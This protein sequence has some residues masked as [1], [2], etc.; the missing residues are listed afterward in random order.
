MVPR[1]LEAERPCG[2][3]PGGPSALIFLPLPLALMSLLSSCPPFRLPL[4]RRIVNEEDL[5][6]N[7]QRPLRSYFRE[8]RS[9]S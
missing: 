1:N 4:S 9:R 8:S 2:V 5:D 6:G 3:E 7:P